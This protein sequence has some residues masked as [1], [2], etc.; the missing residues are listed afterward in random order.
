MVRRFLTLTL[1]LA[2]F[3]S[4]SLAARGVWQAAGPYESFVKLSPEQR[5]DQWVKATP[6]VRSQ[7]AQTHATRWLTANEKALSAA[8]VVSLKEAI[9]ML[10]PAFY[11]DPLS[12]AAMAQSA[13]LERKLLCTIWKSDVV[14][15]FQPTG[16]GMKITWMDDV[17]TWLRKCYLGN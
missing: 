10:T 13:A 1:C 17:S 16:R 4:L 6:D 2:L 9:M 11:G 15:A 7:I 12:P 14:A 8:Q 5:M 3:G